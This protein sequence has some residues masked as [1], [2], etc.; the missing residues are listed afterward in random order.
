MNTDKIK[1]WILGEDSNTIKLKF[2]DLDIPVFVSQRYFKQL[3]RNRKYVI[4]GVDY[5]G[6][7]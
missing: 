2:S 4:Q 1:I 6:W 3:I 7:G 5:S